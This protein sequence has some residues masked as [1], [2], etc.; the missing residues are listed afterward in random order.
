MAKLTGVKTVSDREIECGGVRYE[1][2][3]G[4]AQ[5]G[6]IVRSDT[7]DYV[8]VRKN[9]FYAV[10]TQDGVQGFVDD[11]E[12]YR[13][14][15]DGFIEVDSG[16]LTVFR[17][18]ESV[19][20]TSQSP[21]EIRAL[22]EQKRTEIAELEAQIAINVDDYVRVVGRTY[23]DELQVGDVAQVFR[24]DPEDDDLPYYLR[25]IIGNTHAW[26]R[27]DSIVKITPAEAKASLIAQIEELFAE[28]PAS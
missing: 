1:V 21:A 28:E 24:T 13:G 6:D 10:I 11:A 14:I 16:D 7:N 4:A 20:Q 2:A 3:E 19:P 22:I 9:G 18:V 23:D 8:D 17:R 5:S 27:A 15:D 26:A 25:S 12:D